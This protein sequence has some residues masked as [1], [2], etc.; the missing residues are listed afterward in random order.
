MNNVAA[1]TGLDEENT[2]AQTNKI[3]DDC[4]NREHEMSTNDTNT[5]KNNSKKESSPTSESDGLD[6]ISILNDNPSFSTFANEDLFAPSI[7]PSNEMSVEYNDS[8]EH[9]SITKS[10]IINAIYYI[11]LSIFVIFIH[12]PREQKDVNFAL[13]Y[14]L[15][16]SINLYRTFGIILTWIFSFEL[17]YDLFVQ[18]I[19]DVKTR[20][21][22]IL[23]TF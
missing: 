14:T 22:S 10:I 5:K 1:N 19:S 6:D 3:A 18:M 15:M 20:T 2:K 23:N 17:V 4:F 8:K 12:M 9:K 11:L 7:E 13:A 21:Q 16:I